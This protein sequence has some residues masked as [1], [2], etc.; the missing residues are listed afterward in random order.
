VTF[1]VTQIS[2]LIQITVPE[3]AVPDWRFYSD[4]IK[5]ASTR[6]MAYRCGPRTAQK[7]FLLSQFPGPSSEEQFSYQNLSML[8]SQ[9]VSTCFQTKLHLYTV[10]YIIY[11]IICYYLCCSSCNRRCYMDAVQFDATSERCFA[12][13]LMAVI[14]FAARAT[15]YP[16]AMPTR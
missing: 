14:L 1:Y 16:P 15:N 13:R 4:N 8:C 12:A 2:I 7:C 6:S 3:I 11:S 10:C 9:L 5:S